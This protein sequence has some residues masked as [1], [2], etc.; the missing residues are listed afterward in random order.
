MQQRS[1]LSQLSSHSKCHQE[2][3]ISKFFFKVQEV[4]WSSL[5]LKINDKSKLFRW[6]NIK[7]GKYNFENGHYDMDKWLT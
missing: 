5:N 3:K 1:N 7:N 6:I 2:G 4:S